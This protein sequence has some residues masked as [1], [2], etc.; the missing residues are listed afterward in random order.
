MPEAWR[1]VLGCGA[2]GSL[3]AGSDGMKCLA[4]K[5]RAG[6][7]KAHLQLD[8]EGMGRALPLVEQLRTGRHGLNHELSAMTRRPQPSFMLLATCYKNIKLTQ[9][10]MSQ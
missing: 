5:Q 10:A 9:S 8:D 7:K 3:C 1:A 4:G 2:S 6:Q